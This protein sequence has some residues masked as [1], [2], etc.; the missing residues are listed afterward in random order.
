MHF[1]KESPNLKIFFFFLEG[2]GG[3]GGGVEGVFDP[4][5][6][7]MVYRIKSKV[8]LTLILTL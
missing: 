2:G 8:I 5:P 4:S 7:P 1:D 6:T 3:E